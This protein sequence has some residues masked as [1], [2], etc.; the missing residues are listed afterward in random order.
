MLSRSLTLA[1]ILGVL[2]TGLLATMLYAA[3][4]THGTIY[5]H[6]PN[7]PVGPVGAVDD[8]YKFDDGFYDK[9]QEMINT[10][11][12]SGAS[13]VHDGKIYYD[14]ILV[15]SRDDGDD[16]DPDV[17]SAENKLAL[18]K[19]LHNIDSLN[20][21]PGQVLSFVTASVPVKEL[22]G[23]SLSD[24]VFGIGDG[25]LAMPVAVDTARITIN[26]TPDEMRTSSGT[27]L[28]GSGVVV[29]V[30]DTGI[31]H[32]TALNPKVLDRVVCNNNGC[33]STNP[34]TSS[35]LSSHGT[36]VAHIIAA[37]LDID[38]GIAPGVHL[39][40][41]DVLHNNNSEPRP[42]A[43][44][45]IPYA[46]GLDWSL[47]NGADVV[48]LSFG[49]A[50][51][52]TRADDTRSLILNEAVDKGMVVVGAAGNN[53]TKNNAPEYSTIVSPQCAHNSITVGGIN[54]RTDNVITMH[55]GSSRG[56][57]SDDKPR[58]KPDVVA[59]AVNLDLLSSTS[60][61]VTSRGTGTSYAAPH[62][63]AT[64]AILLQAN[65]DLTPVEIK[66]AILLGADWKAPMCTSPDFEA[67]NPNDNC[68]YAKRPATS[69]AAN[70]EASLGILNNAGFGILNVN[71]T[72]EYASD[73]S[74]SRN[75][76]MRDHLDTSTATKKYT[77]QVTDT[78]EPVKVILTWLAHPHGGILDPRER[79]KN[80]FPAN[81]DFEIRTPTGSTISAN[82]KYQTSEFAVFRPSAT[83]TYTV[84]VTG[85]NLDKINKPEQSYA[86]ASTNSLA[87]V[88]SLST[89]RAPV[90]QAASVIIDPDSDD[91]AIVRLTATDRD[92]DQVSFRVSSDPK[93][94]TVSTDEQITKTSS[95]MFYNDS[96]SFVGH[97]S[98]TVVPYDGFKAGTP[99]VI[100]IVAER[101]PAGATT[102][103]AD[104]S[105][106]KK[107]D[108]LEVSRGHVHAKYSETFAGPA[109]P[110]SAMY[111]GSVNM[112]GVDVTFTTSSGVS[113][114]AAIPP[115]GDRMIAFSSPLT[116]RTVE[117]SADGL[118]EESAH[119][120]RQNSMSHPRQR[121]AFSPFI[122]DDVRM[123]AGY[124]PA[125]C[126]PSALSGAQGS[127]SSCPT[128]TTLHVSSS[129]ALVIPD[130]GRTQDT[131]DTI[132]VPV[133][134]T[135]KSISVSVDITH[136]YAGDIKV[137]VS[138]P[139]G[140]TVTLH[141]REGGSSNDVK[142]TY[143]PVTTAALKTVLDTPIAGNWT[144]SIGD[145]VG[146]DVGTLNSWNVSA[147]Y[148]PS[149][150]TV[151]SNATAAHTI[152][153]SDGFED[154][155]LTKWTET[156][157]GDWTVTTSQAQAVPTIPGYE[158][159]N[160]VLHADD[161]DS[162][163][164]V[165]TKQAIDLSGYKSATL[166][167]WRFVDRSLDGSEY[168]KV[169]VS[170]GSSWSTVLHWSDNNNGDDGT[171]HR[172]TY[173]LSQYVGKSS[174][175]VRFVT[176]QSY[177]NEDV[178]VDDVVINATKS[179]PNIQPPPPM[180][181]TYSVYVADTD[182]YEILAYTPAGA[183]IDDIVPRKSGGLGKPFDA[184]FGPD[185]HLYVSDISYT[186]IRKYNG[187]TGAPMGKSS[188]SAEW[189][190]V[191]S[192]PSGLVWKE[193]T[194][195]VATLKGVERISL[196]GSS[197]GLFGDASRTPSTQGAPKLASPYDVAFCPD[198]NMYVADRALDSVL[199]YDGATG[200]YKGT[201]QSAQ[202][203]T[204]RPDT[205][206][207]VGLEC[208]PA[209]AGTTGTTSLF[210]SGGDPGRINEINLTTKLLTGNFTLSID[211][212]YG[213]DSD[214]AG[215]LYVA[216]KD[217]NNIVR[218]SPA[219]AATVFATGGLDDPRGVSV[220]PEYTT[221]AAAGSDSA[222]PSQSISPEQYNDGPSVTLR[223]DTR[224]I[225][226]R[227]EVA[228][229]ATVAYTVTATDPENDPITFEL[230]PHAVESGTILLSDHHNSTATVTL[231]TSG[232]D[233]G[234][235]AF[236]ITA[237]DGHN[238]ERAVYAVVVR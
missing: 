144:L 27:V 167:F 127:S 2:S 77:F 218:I 105:V 153:F 42:G 37:A 114:T 183:Y 129:P 143:D 204:Q 96:S 205:D 226:F 53:G 214:P 215:N 3:E 135:L 22:P 220:G 95:R 170:D 52:A 212:P 158:R 154:G 164:T 73:K 219:G 107:W 14:I 103:A 203:G 131:S 25:A 68:S 57:V 175:A 108:T 119:D 228:Q 213:I 150:L 47:K 139:S 66:A 229:N 49:G 190:S 208:G 62:V 43:I 99:V 231:D 32:A 123:F 189:V 54:D 63:S 136:T 48:N 55:V 163:C 11:P 36:K 128:Y 6:M 155:T 29:G 38:G 65:P 80:T 236:V 188:A 109:Y 116:I 195:Y 74:P 234:T 225:L 12:Q 91:P 133:N 221:S 13:N 180:T 19:T 113:Y 31:N 83:G 176:Q 10:E 182:D 8:S 59:P 152:V 50:F 20:I 86:I 5:D 21:R 16:R 126:V 130:N 147:Q 206:N 222:P 56:P 33:A 39:L 23:L 181:N 70:S 4:D 196:S 60:G 148:E 76:V 227:T 115:S 15:V 209:I 169:E 198:G 79:D 177:T 168:L 122:Y 233:A 201:V 140:K 216:N 118:D 197:L 71:Q 186:K 161:C 138:S 51:C 97:D 106:V 58:L 78:S 124:V 149:I 69:A 202:Q 184:A 171:W 100:T 207:A 24:E 185:G 132:L 134:G 173:D 192:A 187:D 110:I 90:A 174:V 157:E 178:Q 230:I 35:T 238:I 235:Y 84:T 200:K 26:A 193:N 67:N 64:A 45:A 156:G 40:D 41:V 1:M 17:V 217:D 166:S 75:H 224:D 81:L 141:N 223:N 46:H 102:P 44:Q 7:G 101:L 162:T 94:G 210:Q 191:S 142:K 121:N 194:L 88:P 93:H 179:N 145:Y 85:F 125:S 72:L 165:T 111:L 117:L 98:F 199:Y 9:I 120:N 34:N 172:E 151:A 61:T 18:V 159:D 211:E 160:K 137:E 104:S 28:N 30:L 232:M 237:S 112:E 92:N 89:N 82:S 146:G 87:P